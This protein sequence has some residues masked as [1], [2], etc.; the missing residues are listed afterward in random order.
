MK[1]NEE[2]RCVVHT[3]IEGL[4]CST[5]LHKYDLSGMNVLN[6]DL[7]VKWLKNV[8][9][10][11]LRTMHYIVATLFLLCSDIISLYRNKDCPNLVCIVENYVAT[12]YFVSRHYFYSP[13]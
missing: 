6:T 12:Q 5:C 11:I 4:C 13:G 7:C 10:T 8:K 9:T 1:L 2:M 3:I